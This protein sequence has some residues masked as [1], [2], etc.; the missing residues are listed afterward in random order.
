MTSAS[1]SG[2]QELNELCVICFLAIDLKS[3]SAT[4]LVCKNFPGNEVAA[5]CFHVGAVAG[6]GR[7]TPYLPTI[8]VSPH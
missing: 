8:P 2:P 7:F 1:L 6:P 4:L 3:K 5:F